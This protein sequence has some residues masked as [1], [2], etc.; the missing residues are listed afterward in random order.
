MSDL[1]FSP[2]SREDLRAILEYI[3]RDNPTAATA[4]V[5]RLKAKC[6]LLVEFPGMGSQR[7]Q[8]SPGLRGFAVGNYIIF[9]RPIPEGVRVERVL[10]GAQDIDSIFAE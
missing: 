4:F 8:L 1:I 9:Y 7:D 5:E 10:H 6:K 2:P 3:S